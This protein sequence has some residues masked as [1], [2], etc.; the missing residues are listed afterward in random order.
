MRPVLDLSSPLELVRQIDEK[1]V[2]LLED[3]SVSTEVVMT[4][5]QL[6]SGDFAFN[7]DIGIPKSFLDAG[8]ELDLEISGKHIL[9]L[10]SD[11]KAAIEPCFPFWSA[12][13]SL[14]LY[15]RTN[16]YHIA[17]SFIPFAHKLS[18]HKTSSQIWNVSHSIH[19]CHFVE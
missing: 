13:D 14:D 6:A 2:E 8:G 18:V 10:L 15:R 17:E 9:A 3:T 1:V 11:S 5:N 19:K 16:Q 4:E 7:I 12:Y